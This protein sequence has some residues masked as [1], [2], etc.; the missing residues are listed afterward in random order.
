MFADVRIA[1]APL[2]VSFVAL[3]GLFVAAAGGL[4]S[5]AAAQDAG[6]MASDTT[7]P[8]PQTFDWW[9]ARGV[10]AS[11]PWGQPV[12]TAATRKLLSWTTDS[13][14]VT[15]WVDHIP[16]HASVPSPSDYFGDPVGQ[17]GALHGV[18][19]IHGYLG[20]LAG[21][22]PRVEFRRL[23]ETEEGRHVP[24]A[25]VGSEENLA[26]LDEVKAGMAALADP[27]RT[28]EAEAERLIGE[29]PVIYTFYAGLHSTETGPPEMVME[30]AY[31]LAASGAP[32]I[33]GIRDG[34]LV[35]IIP[36]A[37]PDGRDRVVQWHRKH[38]TDVYDL[39]DEVPG[40]PYWGH[41]L[42]HDNNRDG[43]QMSL[44]LT[45]IL[46]DLALEWHHPVAHDLHESVPLLYTSTGTG[47][48]NPTIDPI[49]VGEWTWFANYEVTSLTAEGLPGVWTH[50]FYSGWYPG[51]LMWVTNNDL[52]AMGRFYET[53]GNS[54]PN[55]MERTTGGAAEVDWFRQNP[56]PDS[57]LWSLRNNTNF[58]QSGA[59]AAL[60]LAAGNRERLLR[61]YWRK[62]NR[63][64]EKGRTEPPYLWVI[65]AD[66]PRR[67]DAAYMV[68]LLRRHGI[69]V[70]RAAEGG[71]F[72]SEATADGS[73]DSVTVRPGDYVVRM[74]QPYRNYALTL[75]RRQ[76]FP[77]DA[78]SPYDDV[79]WTYPLMSNVEAAAADERR[80]LELETEP[81]PEEEEIRPAPPGEAPA[82]GPEAEDTWHAV[83]PRASAHSVRAWLGL[84]EE[85]TVYAAED[86]VRAGDRTL[87]PG[88]WLVPPPEDDGSADDEG[89]ASAEALS[90]IR[91]ELGMEVVGLTD[92]E[93]DAT[94]RHE[95]DEPRVALL[96]T[97]RNTQDD[98]SVRYALDHFEVP[99][100][101]IA[102]DDLTAPDGSPVDLRDRFDVILM[103]TQ[104]AGSDARE[105]F[106][107][108]DPR[109]S[110][111]PYRSSAEY[112]ALGT[113]DSTDDMTGGMGYEGLT[114]LRDF[115]D[116]GGTLVL[117]G[118]AS[119]LATGMGL[120]R[121]VEE[122]DAGSRFV[123]GSL[124]QGRIADP[125]DPLTY[126][127]GDEV[128]LYH[129]F[130]PYLDVD[131]ELEDRVAVEYGDADGLLLSG[132]ARNAD[133]MAGEPALVS[134]PR[135]E[136]TVVLFGFDPMH[137]FQNHGNF[138]L[139]WNALMNWN[140]L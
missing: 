124:V 60:T 76:S 10:P 53:F 120:V 11:T 7:P 87:P 33:E 130:G 91:E 19:E 113:P 82:D 135:E 109:W 81:V 5:S 89:A 45:R 49:T 16:E 6:A 18:D 40:P 22:S 125:S 54:V 1:R 77:E 69:E 116:G 97:W 103:A 128:P 108:I 28:T 50:D 75:M 131:D 122:D 55:T 37:E 84:V 104:G 68:D 36:V 90:W 72:A 56:A 48:Y 25:A 4:P 71:R 83:L 58:M 27:R 20:A 9:E 112:P 79:A 31:R 94:L 17:P 96:H 110:P 121:D 129:R 38:N 80:A 30:M 111:L 105:I 39:E 95:L 92:D 133:G 24:L 63:S 134:V 132:L 15:P 61:Q 126:G 8:V 118:T 52:N 102:V 32:E 41:Y 88:T 86:S 26:R 101:Y 43:L 62:G 100:A 57:T 107:G 44:A 73:T 23:G 46:V 51:Y 74:D 139:V 93:A 117:M 42:F 119:R 114:A 2:Y 3:A 35:F 12:D 98:G 14:Y 138:A 29:L 66:Q 137:R 59:L 64:L 78:P 13:A 115:V 99:Y 140:D 70:S 65:P 127:Y 47:P 136:G 123:P 106:Q 34:A 21:A 67:A 85:G